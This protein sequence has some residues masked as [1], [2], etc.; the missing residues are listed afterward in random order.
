MRDQACANLRTLCV[1]EFWKESKRIFINV[2]EKENESIGF[3]VNKPQQN[4]DLRKLEP[5][6]NHHFWVHRILGIR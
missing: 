3:R 5:F 2:E 4:L 6:E 1:N